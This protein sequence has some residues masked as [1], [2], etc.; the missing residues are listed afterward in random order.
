MRVVQ[1]GDHHDGDQVGL[2]VPLELL[3]D[4][5]AVAVGEHEVEEDEVGLGTAD[6]VHD[7]RALRSAGSPRN[8]GRGPGWRGYRS[9][10]ARRRRSARCAAWVEIPRVDQITPRFH[11]LAPTLDS[12]AV[13]WPGT[14][15]SCG[16]PFPAATME[17]TRRGRR[18]KAWAARTD[19]RNQ[20]RAGSLRRRIST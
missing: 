14:S 2:A 9:R 7:G 11:C 16:R 6:V 5:E 18:P 13:G 15:R 8:R 4:L 20:S 10:R 1:R 12:Q 19:R 3:A 17:S